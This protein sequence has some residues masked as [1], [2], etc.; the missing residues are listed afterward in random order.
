MSNI[1]RFTAPASRDIESIIDYVAD[2]SS[3]DA[4]ERLL[5]KINEKC[6][7]LANF[8]N[9]GRKR[10]ELLPLLRSF[11]VD[12]YLIFYRAIAGGIEILRIVSGYRNLDALFDE[13]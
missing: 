6:S 10:N 3:F 2:N 5:K 4:A 1:C 12:D 13:E 11:P 7:N 8:P 9:M